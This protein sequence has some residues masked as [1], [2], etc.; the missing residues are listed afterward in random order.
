MQP[1]RISLKFQTH[2]KYALNQLYVDIIHREYWTSMPDME[3]SFRLNVNSSALC[4]S[5]S[6]AIFLPC[7]QIYLQTEYVLTGS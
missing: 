5:S 4:Y 3:Y 7:K 1:C 2:F 6:S